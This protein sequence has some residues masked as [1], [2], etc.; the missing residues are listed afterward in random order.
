MCETINH[1]YYYNKNLNY[2][3][4]I[5]DETRKIATN[6]FFDNF[7]IWEDEQITIF[8]KLINSNEKIN[9]IDIGANVGLYSLYA[10]FLPNATFYAYEPVPLNF[11]LLND[12]IL[13]NNI[14]NVKTFDIAISNEKKTSIMNLCKSHCGL[15]TL[16]NNPL[17][18]ND[19]EQISV[20]TD[21]LDNLFYDKNIKIDFLKIDTEG[22]EFYILK[23]GI[24]TIKTYKPI[25][26]IEYSVQNM[27]Q[28]N[29]TENE[30]C[31]LIEDLDY[32]IINRYNEEVI[33]AHKDYHYN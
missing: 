18:F 3:F 14:N 26:Q 33:I 25:I 9:I 12:N 21:T 2:N 4:L 23:G 7:S 15:H 1:T 27:N 29:I 10:K 11:K 22:Y 13:L 6:C 16:G 19:I 20:N 5:T 17:R 30:L 31:K 32:K 24:N 28:C 8:Y